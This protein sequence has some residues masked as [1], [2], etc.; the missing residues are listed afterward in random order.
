M[1]ILYA[2]RVLNKIEKCI[3]YFKNTIFIYLLNKIGSIKKINHLNI[4][5]WIKNN[6]KLIEKNIKHLFSTL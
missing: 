4:I 5:M 6:I 1:L 2:S 3:F